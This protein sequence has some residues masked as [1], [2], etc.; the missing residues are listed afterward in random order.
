M[1]K[2]KNPTVP[3]FRRHKASGRAYVNL[4]GRRHYLGRY[5]APE[6]RERYDRLI[7]EW[8]AGG[9]RLHVDASDITVVELIAR[10]MTHAE[11]YYVRPNGKQTVE[12]GQL[13]QAFR[14]LRQ[15]YGRTHACDFGP[16][17]LKAYQ[18]HQVRTGITRRYVNDQVSRIK[19]L[20]RWAVGEE[21]VPKDMYHGL[22]AVVGLSYG[23]GGRETDDVAPV[24]DDDVDAIKPFVSSQVWAMIQL[25]RLT[26]AR[27]SEVIQMR[28]VDLDMSGEV[29]RYSPASHKNSHR[30]HRR[31]VYLGPK[32]QEVVIPFLTGR[33]VDAFLFSPR[34]AEQERHARAD[35]HRHAKQRPNRKKTMRRT[36]DCYARDGYRRSIK[37]ACEKAEV[38]PWYPLQLRHAAATN[39]RK[40]FG[41]E[42]AQLLCGHKSADITQT[43]ALR[44][45]A[46]VLAVVS[47]I[48]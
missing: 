6:A 36:T 15:L 4:D 34:E 25:Q 7:S 45:E 8:L 30:G 48:G 23:R 18:T 28:A 3:P 12:V 14:P 39:A 44:D 43:Y 9:R 10:Y 17:S 20:F 40:A 46:K 31:T 38:S 42:A 21:L 2:S 32:A 47:K 22:Q 29:W 37:R 11:S 27:P 33:P 1:T 26:A 16:K 13:R 24:S 5:D 35:T 41:L 19:R